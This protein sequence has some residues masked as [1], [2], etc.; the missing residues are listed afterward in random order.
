MKTLHYFAALPLIVLASG[1]GCKTAKVTSERQFS[2]PAT[3][4]PAIIHVADF[5]LGAAN[6]KQEPGALADRPGPVGRVSER[7]S[8]NSQDPAVRAREI[9]D[10]MANSLTKDLT[11]SGF[12][13]VRL[14]PGMPVPNQGWL[15]RGIFLQ[16][17]EGNR[18]RRAMIG[19]GQGQTDLQ[20]VA[21]VDDLSR[22]MPKSIYEVATDATSGSTAGAAPTLA[23]GPYGAAA[24]FVMAGQDLEK[25]VK[26]TAAQIAAQLT[27]RVEQP[28]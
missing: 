3:T 19:F 24:R 11:K 2:P 8:G 23:L 25:N 17:D 1:L 28:K 13:A 26:Q 12:T 10:L 27:K 22:G 7:L 16:V 20:L 18:L 9:V 21:T 15:V 4:K 14:Q 6:M 5:E